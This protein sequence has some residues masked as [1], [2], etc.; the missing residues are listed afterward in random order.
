M[1]NKGV[2][3]TSEFHSREMPHSYWQRL[4][5]IGAWF[6]LIL[7]M[8][9][10]VLTLFLTAHMW[11]HRRQEFPQNLGNARAA[12]LL[13]RSDTAGDLIKFAVIGDINNGTETFETVVARLREEQNVDFLVLLGD[14]AADPIR[15]LHMYFIGE[16]AETG[17]HLP[18][19]IVAG[20]HDVGPGKFDY[21]EFERLYGPTNF[22]FIYHDNLFIGLGVINDEKKRF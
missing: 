19:F 8:V 5:Q 9:G 16:F 20:N 15:D 13:A 2:K 17:F 6:A 7:C 4:Y 12:A 22:A 14:C 11:E 1:F 10:I 3:K 18:T 21:P